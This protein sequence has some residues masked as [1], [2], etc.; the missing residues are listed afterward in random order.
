VR[1]GI[2]PIQAILRS[3]RLVRWNFLD[4][5]G[6]FIILFGAN[7]A[8]HEVWVMPADISWLTGLAIAGHALT[9]TILLM[10][11]YQFFQNRWVV[12]E[13]AMQHWADLKAV[14]DESIDGEAYLSEGEE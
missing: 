1:D 3:I 12:T 13:Q 9:T 5:V 8:L 2:N 6:F 14:E 4:T 11:S 10:S 7:W